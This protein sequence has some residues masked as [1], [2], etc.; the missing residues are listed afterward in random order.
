MARLVTALLLLPTVAAA[1]ACAGAECSADVSLEEDDSLLEAMNMNLLQVDL[2]MQKDLEE[3]KAQPPPGTIAS[4]L[5]N[6]RFMCW[7]GLPTN[8]ANAAA[9]VRESPLYRLHS[10][11]GKRVGASCA[12]LGYTR[13]IA[14]I[15]RCRAG[16]STWVNPVT[17]DRDVRQFHASNHGLI[18][19]FAYDRNISMNVAM[20]WA[21]CAACGMTRAPGGNGPRWWGVDVDHQNCGTTWSSLGY[22][23]LTSGY[24]SRV[25]TGSI[26]VENSL[27]CYEGPIDYLTERVNNARHTPHRVMFANMVVTQQT[28]SERGYATLRDVV[29]ECWP[30]AQKWMRTSTEQADMGSFV[31]GQIQFFGMGG[32]MNSDLTSC[33]SCQA[34]GAN[35]DRG[36][37]V[38]WNG[39]DRVPE[40]RFS[41][42]FCA[43]LAQTACSSGALGQELCTSMGH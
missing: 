43:G 6:S 29:D 37:L 20:E 40:P 32:S 28:C 4:I 25:A 19:A 42:S 9:F 35:R 33:F 36:M 5:D 10:N 3:D 13:R 21:D 23:A 15:D 8:V 41:Q 24:N 17:S 16:L 1:T 39:G 11:E 34:G 7:E 18:S 22:H 12:S 31:G 27:V 26:L 2:H 14:T 30:S 38:T